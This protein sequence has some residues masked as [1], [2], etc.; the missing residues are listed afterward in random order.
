MEPWQ[1]ILIMALVISI[2]MASIESIKAHKIS[3]HIKKF[4]QK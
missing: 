4:K 2:V 3:K 1:G